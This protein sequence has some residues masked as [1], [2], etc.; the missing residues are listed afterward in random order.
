MILADKII[1][2][3]KKNGWS[4]EELAEKLKVSRQ[5]VSKWEGAQT[6]PDLERVLQMSQLFGVT[7]DYLL[8]DELE[9][10]EYSAG[11]A[12]QPL[13]RVSM[14]EANAFLAWRVTAGWRIAIA[15]FLCIV[16]AAPL[17]LLAGTCEYGLL[18]L[19][20][21]QA[22]G[23]GMLILLLTVA[24]A[25]SLF[26]HTGL[27]NAP[28]AY[29]DQEDFEGEYGVLGMV[30]ER[31]KEFS[32][33]YTRGLIIGIALC[34]VSP[35]WLFLAA[36]DGSDFMALVAVCCLLLT[37]GVGMLFLI[38]A[39]VRGASMKKLLKTGEYS[40]KEKGRSRTMSAISSIYWLTVTAVFLA[41]SFVTEAWD[42]TW[43]I[44]AVSGVVY[45]VVVTVSKLMLDRKESGNQ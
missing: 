24:A 22:A 41:V 40:A 9:Q 6:V 42:R 17:I 8:K 2:L 7:T 27:K 11:E 1:A 15:T 26:I 34:V 14:A 29:L 23:I 32:G 21:N 3:R 5:A 16:A 18:P 44:W 37:V 39:A 38:P 25:V 12:E 19:T 31:Q 43:I 20:E 30:K 33:A 13:R 36:M 4:Q 10:E 35:C 45:A 28:Y